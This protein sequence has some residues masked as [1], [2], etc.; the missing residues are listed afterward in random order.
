METGCDAVIR[1][2]LVDSALKLHLLLIFHE[3]HGL[4]SGVPRL[5]VWLGEG[6]W[7]VAAA[8]EELTD[9]GF[10]AR[11]PGPAGLEYRLASQPERRMLLE[12]LA[13]CFAD[14]QRRDTVYTLLR[15]ADK[16]RRFQEWLATEQRAVG[17]IA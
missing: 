3:Q 10:L 8:L 14:P 4:R 17:S 15:A 11:C 16:E 7:A 6:P 1:T 5:S 13:A 9:A 2:G 12:W